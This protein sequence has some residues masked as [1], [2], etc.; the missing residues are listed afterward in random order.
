M[1]GR[2]RAR[3]RRNA[4]AGLTL[5]ELSVALLVVSTVLLA[6]AS[7][8]SSSLMATDRAQ[9]L[10]EAALFLETTFEDTQAVA[11]DDLLALNG[12]QIFDA[13]DPAEADYVV[14]LSVFQVEVGLLQVRAELT[15]RTSGLQVAQL[16]TQRSDR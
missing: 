2:T 9:R 10:T 7:A 13:A 3:R 15:D 1:R 11:Y 4:E 8:F 6:S 12:N 5:V 16:T 14:D